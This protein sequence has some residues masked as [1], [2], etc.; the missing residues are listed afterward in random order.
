VLTDQIWNNSIIDTKR[1]PFIFPALSPYTPGLD[2]IVRQ[3]FSQH[4]IKDW[5]KQL[6]YL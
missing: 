2:K 1:T 6:K 4:L 5:K 3:I